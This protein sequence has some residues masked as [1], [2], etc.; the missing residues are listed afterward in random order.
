MAKKR[1][2]KIWK[3]A[4]EWVLKTTDEYYYAFE[5]KFDIIKMVKEELKEVE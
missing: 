5:D 4:L 2:G 3:A 1:D